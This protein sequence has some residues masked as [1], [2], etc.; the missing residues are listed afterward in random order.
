MSLNSL[1]SNFDSLPKNF[2]KELENQ[3]A[4]ISNGE[5]LIHNKEFKIVFEKA[6]E[7]GIGKRTI[8]HKIPK[9]EL[10]IV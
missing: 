4:A 5:I 3:W 7:M 2:P 9:R 8:F 10:I 6:N 1:N